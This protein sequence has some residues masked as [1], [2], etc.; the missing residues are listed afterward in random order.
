MAKELVG[1]DYASIFSIYAMIAEDWNYQET[2]TAFIRTQE[3]TAEYAVLKAGESYAR[4]FSAMADEYMSARAADVRNVANHLINVL[5][6]YEEPRL[7]G[8]EPTILVDDG[9][10]P[11]RVLFLDREWIVGVV[12]RQG[13]ARSHAA[14]LARALGIPGIVRVSQEELSPEWDGHMAV[15]NGGENKLIIDPTP[16]ALGRPGWEPRILHQAPA[17][18]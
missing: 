12:A 8:Q 7:R 16:A 1:E 17:L 13:N 6:E 11:E 15:L 18:V 9:F 5:I 4:I 14:E 3:V 2:V 10:S